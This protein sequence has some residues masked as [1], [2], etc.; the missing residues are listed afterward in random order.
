MRSMRSS[1]LAGEKCFK[2]N[3]DIQQMTFLI[4]NTKD[5][6]KGT[7]R[8]NVANSRERSKPNSRESSQGK[9][10]KGKANR[11]D[12]V[13]QEV[14]VQKRGEVKSGAG[15]EEHVPGSAQRNA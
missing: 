7:D 3:S 12:S 13:A 10:R 14:T 9:K 6:V 4:I 8:K 5:F 1:T 15:A 2:R 11:R